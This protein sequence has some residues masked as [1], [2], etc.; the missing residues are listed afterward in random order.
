MTTVNIGKI[1]QVWK[2]DYSAVTPY[3]YLDFVRYS[4]N[5][6]LCLQESTGNAPAESTYWT[7][8]SVHGITD[9]VSD[10]TPQLGGNLDGQD[11]IISKAMLKD[12]GYKFV[13]NGNS[14]TTAQVFDCEDGNVQKI[15]VTGNFS[16]TITNWCPTGNFGELI[17]IFEN[18]GTA[19]IEFP[20][21][22]WVKPDGTTTTSISD[23]L[24]ANTGRTTLQTSGTDIFYFYG[25]SGSTPFGGLV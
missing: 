8:L 25:V 11:Y 14:G 5:L 13:D 7:A 12:I 20:T 22:N 3:T 16:F 19:T 9:I 10:T 15:T 1:R 23:Y 17:I 2:G 21:T 4:D 18:A 6:W 24:T